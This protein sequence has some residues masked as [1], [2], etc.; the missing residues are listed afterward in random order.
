MSEKPKFGVII[1]M[2]EHVAKKLAQE[3]PKA[4]DAIDS[5]GYIDVAIKSLIDLAKR[6]EIDGLAIAF[7]S[8]DGNANNFYVKG[9]NRWALLGAVQ[10]VA[11]RIETEGNA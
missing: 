6:G 5:A 10:R 3:T 1:N 11:T 7:T 9:S 8:K 4:D 2:G